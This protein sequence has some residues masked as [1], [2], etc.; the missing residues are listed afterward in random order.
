M[1]YKKGD[2]V[3]TI[4]DPKTED[5]GFIKKCFTKKKCLLSFFYSIF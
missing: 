1:K 4:D 3:A 2:Y 5:T